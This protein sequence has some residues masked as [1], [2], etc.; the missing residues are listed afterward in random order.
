MADKQAVEAVGQQSLCVLVAGLSEPVE[1]SGRLGLGGA[2]WQVVPVALGEVGP[3]PDLTGFQAIV[4]TG[5]LGE[6]AQ[7]VGWCKRLRALLA[8]RFLPIVGVLA[9]SDSDQRVRLLA[10]GAD[11]CVS[12]D[13]ELT[14]LRAQIA[15]LV[16]QQ[17]Y[18]SRLAARAADAHAINLRLQQAY[19]R[20]D[21]DLELARR[22]HLGFLPKRLPE[23]ERV[24]FAVCYRP[25]SRL[26][27]DF[28]DVM[29]LDE[30]HVG[31]YLADAMGRGSAVSSLLTLFVKRC[32]QPKEIIGRT[33]RLVPPQEIL[34]QINRELLSLELPDPPMATMVYGIVNCRDGTLRLARA[35]HPHPL[36]VP[37]VGEPCWLDVPGTLLG[38][39][40]ANYPLHTRLLQSGDKVLIYS[41]GVHMPAEVALEMGETRLDLLAV[42]RVHQAEPVHAFVDLLARE[43]LTSKQTADDFTLLALEY[44]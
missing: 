24:G 16:R 18:H 28:Y 43:L 1:L 21:Q 22:L 33:Y 32:V 29:R 12:A 41:D 11:V 27:G 19:A 14:E 26:G 40:E 4:L 44:E 2:G 3:V 30:D 31:F 38:V 5:G 9:G 34:Q 20:M 36:L 35:G 13:V 8:E 15:A 42:A 10:A 6:S 37:R 25:R 17:R 23:V 7:L 39:F